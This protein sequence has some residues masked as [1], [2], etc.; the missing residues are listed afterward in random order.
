[1]S[2][3]LREVSS[4]FLFDLVSWESDVEG[5]LI[6]LVSDGIYVV[7]LDERIT[8]WN[9]AAEQMTGYAARCPPRGPKGCAA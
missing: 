6:D 7:G 8:L 2:S 1:M 9:A 5:Q 3:V 4:P